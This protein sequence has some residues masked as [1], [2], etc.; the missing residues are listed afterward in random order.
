MNR[1]ILISAQGLDTLIAQHEI[2]TNNLA[3]ATTPGFK[4]DVLAVKSFP[5]IFKKTLGELQGGV[6]EDE[7]TSK[8]TQG[9]MV[10]T[11]DPLNVGINGDGFFVVETPEGERYTRSGAFTV[12]VQGQL[13]TTSG[14]LVS[15]ESGPIMITG[16]QIDVNSQGDV[17]C[18]GQ[19]AGTIK[20]VDFEKPYKFNKTGDSLFVPKEGVQP[21]GRPTHT[22]LVQGHIESSNV[23]TVKEM[24]GMITAMRFF[25]A[26]QRAISAH[27]DALRR[28][29]LTIGKV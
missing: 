20:V 17:F 2:L 25:E 29:I 3:N 21:T 18:D 26:N 11:G 5:S 6:H 8:F 15:G 12:D 9:G 27:D 24:V 23:S 16:S 14:H 7:V 28:S 10:K 22:S 1:G 19:L 4:S 13:S